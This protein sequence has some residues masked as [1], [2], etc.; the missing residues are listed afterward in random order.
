MERL[1]KVRPHFDSGMLFVQFLYSVYTMS[2]AVSLSNSFYT[3]CE[4]FESIYNFEFQIF[5]D[6]MNRWEVVQSKLNVPRKLALGGHT[7]FQLNQLMSSSSS[8][9][10]CNNVQR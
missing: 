5:R 3:F 10:R 7:R 9:N 1:C 4:K 2:N 6:H 8:H